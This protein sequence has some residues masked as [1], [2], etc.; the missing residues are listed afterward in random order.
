[1]AESIKKKTAKSRYVRFIE[2]K[3][4]HTLKLRLCTFSVNYITEREETQLVSLC[5]CTEIWLPNL[6][7]VEVEVEAETEI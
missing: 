7:E 5:F 1:M 6:T 2:S 4:E 3:L